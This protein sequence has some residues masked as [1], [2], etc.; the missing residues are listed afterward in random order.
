MAGKYI[1]GLLVGIVFGYVVRKSRICF[2]GLIRDVFLMKDRFNIVLFSLIIVV[3][4]TIYYI[5]SVTSLIRI[6]LYLPPFSLISVALGSFIFGFGAV[7]CSGCLTATLVKCG[8][9]RVSGWLYL[10]LF[11]ISDYFFSAGPGIGVSKRLR[12]ALVVDDDLAV[13]YSYAPL[14]IFIVLLALLLFI[15]K[16]HSYESH[17][18]SGRY[19]YTGIRNILF[20]RSW[21]AVFNSVMTGAVLG[22]VF[23]IS[24]MH[25]RHAGITISSPVMSW[26]YYFTDPVETC[27]G[28]NPYDET[29]G[30]G[31]MLVIGI[32]LGSFLTAALG[33]ELRIITVRK[34]ELF[35]GVIGA[36]LMG[37]GAVWGL[38][39]LLSNGLVG[40]AQLS[41]KSWY[42][43]VFLTLGIWASTKIFFA[44][45]LRD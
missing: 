22:A 36:L 25:G 4:G 2:T 21:P 29:L 26:V 35:R 41:V 13:R 1:S 19:S 18:V 11:M 38:G 33:G 7:M 34:S 12:T 42:A 28:C 44:S 37:A 5:L 24:E 10:L 40:T 6:P 31:S 17:S 45:Y 20:E 43:L 3:E 30:W 8:D 16:R 39:C 14:F 15:I 32:I 9:G 27:G 23:L